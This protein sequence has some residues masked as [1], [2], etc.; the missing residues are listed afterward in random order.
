[1]RRTRPGTA[2]RDTIAT[3]TD[4]DIPAS[5]MTGKGREETFGYTNDIV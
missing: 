4:A 1:M 5:M 3:L 2:E